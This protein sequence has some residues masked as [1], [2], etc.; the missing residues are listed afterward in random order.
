MLS[1]TNIDRIPR[2]RRSIYLEETLD[3]KRVVIT[4]LGTLSPLGNT[5]KETWDSLLEGR[6]G[7]GPITHFDASD[8]ITRFAGEVRGFDPVADLGHKLARRLDRVTQMTVVATKQA[9]D[10]A[11][12]KITETNRDRIGAI[13]GTGVGG[14]ST[15][16]EQVKRYLEK[17]PRWI[18]PFTVP[19]MLPDA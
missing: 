9:L 13:I 1:R 8:L 19:M 18:S 2:T 11:K 6:S 12:L 7:I 16:I 10:H 3:R 14:I 4:G 17:G 15:I 5:V